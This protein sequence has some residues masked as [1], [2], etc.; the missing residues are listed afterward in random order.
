[1][2]HSHHGEAHGRKR[3]G[4]GESAGGGRKWI[5]SKQVP[6]VS[7]CAAAME[8]PVVLYRARTPG[9]RQHVVLAV[10]KHWERDTP[11]PQNLPNR[12]NRNQLQASF[13]YFFQSWTKLCPRWPLGNWDLIIARGGPKQ[14]KHL[15][16]TNM[17]AADPAE[18]EHN[19]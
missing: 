1:M 10:Q 12:V 7:T 3:G 11:P 6:A 2:P 19:L 5:R 9:E 4:A 14:Q 17:N 15:K 16:R 18:M 13:R 8:R